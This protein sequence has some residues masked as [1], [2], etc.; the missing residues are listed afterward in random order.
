MTGEPIRRT[1]WGERI[2]RRD[3]RIVRFLEWTWPLSKW[4]PVWSI[5][6]GMDYST[7]CVIGRKNAPGCREKLNPRIHSGFWKK[8]I[9]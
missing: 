9:K 4:W 7:Y 3:S 8:E 5:K 6:V 1:Y 2:H